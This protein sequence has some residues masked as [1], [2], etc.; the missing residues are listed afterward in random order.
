MTAATLPV[1]VVLADVALM[2]TDRDDDGVVLTNT[3]AVVAYVECAL[4]GGDGR[5]AP[6]T[7]ARSKLRRWQRHGWLAARPDL[8]DGWCEVVDAEAI[9]ADRYRV[10]PAGAKRWETTNTNE[11][12]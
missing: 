7:V 11:R 1:A 5:D 9:A 6:V 4:G 3:E 12:R 2:L 10:R 8:G